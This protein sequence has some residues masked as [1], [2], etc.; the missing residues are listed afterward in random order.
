MGS[1]PG[2][3]PATLPGWATELIELYESSANSQFILSGNV[4]DRFALDGEL[5]GLEQFVL[6][7][8]LPRFDVVLSYDLGA[9]VRVEKGEACFEQWPS[10]P[11]KRPRHPRAAIEMLTHFFRYTANLARIGQRRLQVGCIVLSG[12]LVVPAVRGTA[13]H[14]LGAMA[15]LLRSW[16][17]DD[18]L[19]ESGLAT[20]IVAANRSDLHPLLVQNP[21]AAHL[22]LPMPN[23]HDLEAAF[24]MLAPQHP[25]ALSRY[26]D[27]L[28]RPAQRLAGTTLSAVEALLKTREYRQK[29][30]D[31]VD[32]ARMKRELVERD[33]N[34]LIEFV[35]P[36]RSLSDYTGQPEVVEW[37]RNDLALWRRDELDA[38][39][40]GYLLCG[41]VGTGKTF[42]VECLA[43]E[44]GVPV[45]KLGNFRDRWVGSTESNLER[46]F[47]LLHALGRC[48]VFVDE[49]DQALGRRSGG[50]G[51]D[52][53]VGG[54][55]YSMLADEMSDTRN[56]GRIIWIL[57][58][59]RPDLIEVDLKRPGRIDVKLPLF[60]AVTPEEGFELIRSLGR[61]RGLLF[62]EPAA[63]ELLARVPA[64][65]TPGAAESLVVKV[66]RATRTRQLSAHDALRACLTDYRHPVSS[67]V[68]REQIE[69]AAAEASDLAFVPDVYRQSG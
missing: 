11:A 65:L 21:R 8:L 1:E 64:Q 61:A 9:G 50:A 56:R 2:P 66:F 20:F 17:H 22:E 39:P 33:C 3:S 63:D 57:A 14:D 24:E 69:L 44:A 60:P 15:L 48:Y 36:D 31:D 18:L 47:R 12:H 30:L 68:M 43:G 52:S 62:D 59:S 46:I 23:A 51:G 16:S 45:V 10:R 6:R 19:R 25:I 40:M 4:D 55:V 7:A 53:G 34:G 49:A 42:L 13:D 41:P 28:D 32:L 35:E 67:V 37:L 38:M 27:D 29:P 26:R 5:C 58:S 54:R